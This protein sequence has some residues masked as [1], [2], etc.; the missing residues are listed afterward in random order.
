MIKIDN[1]TKKYKNNI[2]LENTKYTFMQKGLVCLLG[3]SGGGKSTLLNLIAGFDS[4]YTGTIKVCDKEINK[5]STEELCNYR[6]DNIGF[7]FQNYHLLKGYTVLENI[8]LATEL[9]DFTDEE[10]LERANNLL[11]KLNIEE[12]SNENIENLSGGQ[13]QRVAIARALINEPRLILADEP[14]G[15]L[16]RNTSTEIM[17]LLKEI[18][19]DKLVIII[20]HDPKICEFADEIIKIEDKKVVSQRAEEYKISGFLNNKPT[21]TISTFKRG[22]KNFKVHL[23]RFIAVSLA[24]SIGI[25]AFMISLSSRN[26][27]EKSIDDF[28][29]KNTAFN[30]GYIK[31]SDDGTVYNLLNNNKNIDDVYYQYKLNDIKLIFEDKTEAM[32]EKY[33]MPKATESVSYGVMPRK[34]MNEIALTPSLA[35]KFTSNINSLIGKEI[36]LSYEDVEQRLKISG[37]YNAGYDDF[38]VSSDIEQKLYTKIDE[39]DNIENN[40]ISY[41]VKNFEDVVSID[42]MLKMKNISSQNASDEVKSLLD[43]FNSLN[44]LFLIVSVLILAIG[45]F[46]SVVLLAKLQT[47]R[48]KEIGLMSALGFN[49]LTIRKIIVSENILLSSL[50]ALITLVLIFAIYF[51]SKIID[52]GIIVTAP[53]IILSI[54]I[55]FVTVI[56]ISSIVSNKLINTEPAKAL[57]M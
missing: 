31:G 1:L 39:I 16:D 52:F 19:K 34:N 50:S 4:D 25:L 15:A 8:L 22:I 12:K 18:S 48:Y 46:I 42:E 9:N 32:A 53:Q 57:R 56:I 33:P 7:V 35:K 30:N 44:K 41:D 43:T 6:R 14:T 45:L 24:I 51:S 40:S 49:K 17:K 13:K 55:T 38:F 5:M 37:I 26:L 3:P 2:V 10:N 29:E 11:E 54:I 20:T 28:K 21:K 27:M 47:S 36:T 23:G